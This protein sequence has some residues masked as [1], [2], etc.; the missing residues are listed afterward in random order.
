MQSG[1]HSHR[2]IAL[3]GIKFK[4]LH[5]PFGPCASSSF[6]SVP[7]LIPASP[8]SENSGHVRPK[9]SGCVLIRAYKCF[10]SLGA[11]ASHIT[12]EKRGIYY[13][14]FLVISHNDH[15]MASTLWHFFI[16]LNHVLYVKDMFFFK[17]RA[18]N[19]T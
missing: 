5:L 11:C 14:K 10:I 8:W 9:V 13:Y 19:N 6:L 18:R 15:H 17:C 7:R 4:F 16:A 12:L 3:A 2:L 1:H